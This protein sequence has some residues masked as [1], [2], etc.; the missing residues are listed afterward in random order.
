MSIPA[1]IRFRIFERDGFA[2]VYCGQTPPGIVL[3]VDH[4]IPRA[5]GGLDVSTNLVTACYACN[6]GKLDRELSPELIARFTPAPLP[7]LPPRTAPPKKAPLRPLA[8]TFRVTVVREGYR[9]PICGLLNEEGGDRCSCEREYQ[10]KKVWLCALCGEE[11][12]L[13]ECDR[14]DTCYENSDLYCW[15]CGRWIVDEDHADDCERE[16]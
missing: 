2:C 3:E 16:K 10:A 6:R 1:A 5:R 4:L 13:D 14:C 9:C 11:E 15:D 12:V 7:K 8:A